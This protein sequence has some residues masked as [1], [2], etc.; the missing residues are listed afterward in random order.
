M[1]TLVPHMCAQPPPLYAQLPFEDVKSRE[2]DGDADGALDPVHA[3]PLQH[4]ARMDFRGTGMQNERQWLRTTWRSR[5]GNA[6]TGLSTVAEPQQKGL[7]KA[8]VFL[9][10]VT[11]RHTIHGAHQ[12]VPSSMEHGS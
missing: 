6:R 4:P 2:A 9:A 5:Q 3:Q 8:S 1:W 12:S 11:A 7:R 10:G